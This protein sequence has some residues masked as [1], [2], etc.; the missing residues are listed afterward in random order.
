M[1]TDAGFLQGTVSRS[2]RWRIAT[3]TLL[4][5][6]GLQGCDCGGGNTG[7]DTGVADSGVD[8][9]NPM[10]RD[11]PVT[12]DAGPSLGIIVVVPADNATTEMGGQVTLRVR[13]GMAPT[14]TVTV[15]VASDAIDE[16]TAGTASLTFTT[17]NW[18][19]FQDVIVSGVDDSEADGT[20]NYAI[21]FG[22]ST[23]T[24][25]RFAGL[26][27]S[28]ALE[29]TDDETAGISVSTPTGDTTEAGGQST[30]T[31]VLNSQPTAD[32]T[33]A[34]TSSVTTEGTVSPA[35]LVFTR[36][37]WNAPQTV[38]ATGV[39]DAVADGDQPYEV[40]LA[41]TSTDT[42]YAGL[43]MLP[44]AMLNN[45]DDETAGVTFGDISGDTSESG[46]EATVTIVLNSEPTGDV[47]FN[48][49]SDD[50]SEGTT[51]ATSVTFTSVNW[52][53][54]QTITVTGV[55]DVIADGTQTYGIAFTATTST[56]T[57]YAAI[58]PATV[59]VDNVDDET[60]G[61]TVDVVSAISS[62]AGASASFSVVLNSQPSGDV[63]VGFQP[64][65]PSEGIVGATVG[66]TTLTFTADNWNA[67]QL[68]SVTGVDDA[69]ADGDQPYAVLFAASVS[70]DAAYNAL[71]PAN[72]DLTN[73][74]NDS[75][76][77]TVGAIEGTTNE[78]G[79]QTGF[80][81][82]L[83]SEPTANVTLNFNSSDTGE[84]TVAAT[85]LVFTSVNWNAPQRIVLTGVDDAV[86][87]GDQP[88]QVRF[89]ATTSADATYAALTPGNVDATN[90][91]N[92]SAGVTVGTIS[93]DTTE[94]GGTATFSLVL[95]SEPT[96]DV[97]LHFA[98]NDTTEGTSGAGV[99]TF[100]ALN[101]NAPQSIT[102]T[103]VDDAVADG[104][105]P[106][107]IVFSATTSTDAAYAA[108]RPT[109]VS[110][111]NVDN[112]SAG[113]TVGVIS[114]D[115]TEA[116]GQA[117]F[118]VV[119]TSEPTANVTFSLS[120]SD[121]TE[122]TL[123]ASSLVFTPL[124]W[125]APQTV[126]VTGVDDAVADGNQPYRI[127]FGATSSADSAY[128]AIAPASVDVIN[129]DNDSR[130]IIVSP[131]SGNTTEAGG[132]ATFAV[133]LQSEP[134]ASVTVNY[135]SN[136]T[137]EGTTARPNIVFT[138]L[139]W[140]SPQ[141]ITVTGVDDFVADGN[142]VYAIAFSAT[143]SADAGYA[144]ILPSNVSVTN[145][146]NDSAGITVSAISGDTT[147]AG[148]QRTFTTVLTSQPTAPVTVNF[149]SND[150]TEGSLTV[151]SLTFTTANWNAPQSVTVTG[152]NDFVA[153]GNQPY[154]IAF[155]ATTSTD[156]AYAAIR[157]ATVAVIN[158][159]NDSAGITV[160]T[161]S[162][163]TTEAGGTATFSVVLTSQPTANVTVNFA[164]SDTTEGSLPASS[165]TFTPV[166]WNAPQAVTV[167][168]VNDAVADGNQLYAITFSATTSA[169]AG[170]AGLTPANVA[171]TNVDNDS[172]GV[173]V[174]TISGNTTEAGG[175]ATFSLVLTS[176]PTANVTLNFA[177]N[178][179]TEGT[180]AG[181]TR[182][183]TP[184]NWNVPQV[185]TVTGVNDAVADGNQVYAIVFSATTSTDGA[186]ALITPSSVSVTNTD[187][188]TAGITVSAIS[189][190]T[191]EALGT[192][193]FSIVLT[194]EPTANVTLNFAS[195][196]ATEGTTAGN[197][198]TFTN[199]NWNVPQVVTVT[200]VNDDVADG[201]IVYAIAFMATT[202]TD[203]A[204]AAITPMNV[205]VTNIDNDLA[206]ITVSAISGNTTEAGGTATFSIVLGSQP[207]ANVTVNFTSNDV[208]EGSLTVSNRTFT[209]GN[210]NIPQVVTVTGVDDVLFD[211]NITYAIVF[212]ATTSTDALYAAITP[213]NVVVINNDNDVPGVTCVMANGVRW[214]WNSAACGE[215]CNTICA[216]AG[217]TPA[218]DATV[219]AAQD[220]APECTNVQTALGLTGTV[221][222]ASYTYACIED[223]GGAHT[224]TDLLGPLLCSNFAGCPAAHR[225]NMDQLGNAC[226]PGSRRSICGCN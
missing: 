17:E 10:R 51:S 223:Q 150:T 61:I 92:D 27:A 12:S 95:T 210:W 44:I 120:S 52:N 82:V 136:D 84:G 102:V 218:D 106:Y 183:F 79:T 206:A 1:R 161:I 45:I 140:N 40:S 132:T 117:T 166:N 216:L 143:T 160:G 81:I 34:L 138:T 222:I 100:T 53:A 68:V 198:R 109:S 188:D 69:V 205:P 22:P 181:N 56:D 29:N 224:A 75:A 175:T 186:Y 47:T 149:A 190:N 46:D 158:I 208:T 94:A 101:W 73:T 177:S 112:D 77:I 60:A 103:G 83:N 197:T 193:T 141:T 133:V 96:A 110:A 195:N 37:N 105:Q 164:S 126:R 107:Q 145:V 28:A 194:S 119:L 209:S 88:Y 211:G 20:Q 123:A 130:G 93:R 35:S 21:L 104:N 116:G 115:T 87:D 196:D 169:D 30:F 38:T 152:V 214:C 217:S 163:N 171:V 178:D 32:V 3:A 153:D 15:P 8:D 33:V 13:L 131:I 147:E 54:P 11:A 184:A 165:V 221:S 19:A 159:D 146:D 212:S 18:N 155:S 59:I 39:D 86:A 200:G 204:Y 173:T 63:T 9:A 139:N 14:A 172:A 185:V 113:V 124:N 66:V 48:F 201:N 57:N 179:T 78:S 157:P 182:L 191:T 125:N 108:I 199:G 2:R 7:E 49:A 225:T 5:A 135:A 128:A 62:E 98:S 67:P 4:L 174:S 42:N 203:A 127:V 192:A 167:V 70:T 134:T 55:D 41:V 220:T 207:T 226:G 31:V 89:T 151:T 122:G 91:D 76:G 144:A 74:D 213:A 80:T 58:T 65:D 142:Q 36:D 129:R 148:V 162:G 72:I 99:A 24:D 170:Y 26:T 154:G 50:T 6:L 25:T 176:E 97:T 121:T 137:T 156:A 16:G 219:F 85:S 180:T 43:S 118:T 215:P 202:S 189:G 114:G 111:T 71:M 64:N 23:S 187:N 168:G 90:V